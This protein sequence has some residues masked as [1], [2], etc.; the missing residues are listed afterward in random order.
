MAPKIE[1][2]VCV[3]FAVESQQNIAAIAFLEH[4]LKSQKHT[5]TQK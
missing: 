5:H 4:K 1:N 2:D 3:C